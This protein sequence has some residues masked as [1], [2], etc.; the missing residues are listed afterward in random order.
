MRITEGRGACCFARFV[1]QHKRVGSGM[2]CSPALLDISPEKQSGS[3][4]SKHDAGL[5]FMNSL[6]KW[7]IHLIIVLEVGRISRDA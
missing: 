6:R 2:A 4:K 7:G 5:S 3:L 1:S